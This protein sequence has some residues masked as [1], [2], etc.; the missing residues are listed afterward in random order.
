MA[1]IKKC[2]ITKCKARCGKDEIFC[3]RHWFSLPGNLRDEVWAAYA[4]GDRNLQLELIREALNLLKEDER[5]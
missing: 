5:E 3:A 4:A 1:T 2:L